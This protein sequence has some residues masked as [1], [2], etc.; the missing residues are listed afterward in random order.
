MSSYLVGIPAI[1]FDTKAQ[2]ILSKMLQK[3]KEGRAWQL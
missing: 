3:L 1:Y 2:E